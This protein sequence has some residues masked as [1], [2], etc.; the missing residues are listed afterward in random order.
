[1]LMLVAVSCCHHGSHT[2][3][4]IINVS[5]AKKNIPGTRDAVASRA[6]FAPEVVVVVFG[7]VM[8]VVVLSSLW[9]GC[10]VVIVVI[11]MMVQS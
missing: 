7:C 6:P 10:G 3:H 4:T 11:V 2:V 8:V 9:C 1:M 5:N